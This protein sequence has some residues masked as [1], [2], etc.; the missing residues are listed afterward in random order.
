MAQWVEGRVRAL[1][2]W[3]GDLYSLQVDADVEPFQAGQFSKLGMEIDGELVARPY[4]LVNAPHERPLE[5]YFIVVRGGPLS[6]RLAALRPGDRLLVTPRASGFMVMSEVPPARD[7]WLI[8]TGTGVGP[9][10]SIL[11]TDEPWRR[12]ERIV[13][14]HAVRT[15]AE[16]TYR[17]LIDA[18]S[19]RHGARFA[20]VPFVSRETTDFALAGRVPAALADGRLERRAHRDITPDASQVMLCGNPEMVRDTTGALI[21][22]GLKKHRR[23]DPGQISVENYW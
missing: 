20:Y 14:V 15:V 7:L 9:F 1:H 13:L 18:F 10:L 8:A 2:H 17:E 16:L 12:F 23:R 22:R 5:F 11:K 3:S 4:S 6:P 21:A 19:A